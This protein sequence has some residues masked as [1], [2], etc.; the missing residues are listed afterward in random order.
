MSIT[1]T[2]QTHD[3]PPVTPTRADFSGGFIQQIQ[4]DL[5]G[6]AHVPSKHLKLLR[7]E[8]CDIW[9]DPFGKITP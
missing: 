7:W 8:V 2:H 6:D 4:C 1:H 5:A 9:Q 3:V